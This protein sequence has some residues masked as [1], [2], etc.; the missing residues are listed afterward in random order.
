M[1]VCAGQR[2]R[3]CGGEGLTI[4]AADA[5]E[6]GACKSRAGVVDLAACGR[7]VGFVDRQH[8]V[9]GR[10]AVTQGAGDGAADRVTARM[11]R[12]LRCAA[13]GDAAQ[14]GIGVAVDQARAHGQSVAA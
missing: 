6:V 1:H 7:Q 2:A 5:A 14:S 12:T 10:H 13:V 9:G 4:D 8:T 11:N 3:A